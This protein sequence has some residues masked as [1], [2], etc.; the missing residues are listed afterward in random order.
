MV[1]THGKPPPDARVPKDRSQCGQLGT[2]L[3]AHIVTHT[4]TVVNVPWS[5]Q[6]PGRCSDPRQLHTLHTRDPLYIPPTATIHSP[7]PAGL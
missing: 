3:Q 4:G 2:C 5:K 1:R 6:A 7:C